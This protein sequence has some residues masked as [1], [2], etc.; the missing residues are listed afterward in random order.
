M[1]R[2]TYSISFAALIAATAGQSDYWGTPKGIQGGVLF[3]IIPLFLVILNSFGVEVSPVLG[4]SRQGVID[5]DKL[6]RLTDYL[7]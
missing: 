7:R 3:F 6:G 2:F 5:T 4:A 1:L